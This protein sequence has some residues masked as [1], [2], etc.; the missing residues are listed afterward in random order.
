MGPSE[1]RELILQQGIAAATAVTAR[2]QTEEPAAA[3]TAEAGDIDTFA[4]PVWVMRQ[5]GRY[6]PEF[7]AVRSKYKFLTVR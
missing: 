1:Y 2:V 6:L 3:A 7:R 5:A 4:V